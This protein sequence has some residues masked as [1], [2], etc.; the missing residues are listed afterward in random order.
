M[1]GDADMKSVRNDG[2]RIHAQILS[3]STVQKPVLCLTIQTRGKSR[4]SMD[5]ISL[6]EETYQNYAPQG[7]CVDQRYGLYTVA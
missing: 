5:G 2:E 3:L 1:V 7:E 6:Y 4:P